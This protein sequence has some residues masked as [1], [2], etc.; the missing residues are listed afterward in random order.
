ME[1]GTLNSS[2]QRKDMI[3]KLGTKLALD[4]ACC[5]W[6]YAILA[7]MARYCRFMHSIWDIQYLTLSLLAVTFVV[8]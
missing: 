8:C 1:C 2:V 4:V 6:N 5:D 3:L 7:D